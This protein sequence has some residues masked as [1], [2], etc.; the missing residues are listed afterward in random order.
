MRIGHHGAVARKVLGHR[1][2][3]GIAHAE[4]VGG[5]E[6]RHAFG[7]PM[8][9]AVADDFA[10][11]EIQIDA[12]GEAVV[13]ADRAQFTGHEPAHGAGQLQGLAAVLV[14]ATAQEPRR[15]QPG[16]PVPEA[17]HAAALVI[18]R[19]DELRRAHRTDGCGQRRHL[20]RAPVISG[21]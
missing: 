20:L 10:D 14:E 1:G 19:D 6:R 18:H 3:A 12:R 17:L 8:E 5:G 2:H 11:S 13:D 21:E 16:E 15:R 9:R 7:V 4:Q